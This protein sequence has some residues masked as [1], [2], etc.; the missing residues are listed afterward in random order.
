MTHKYFYFIYLF[1]YNGKL[2]EQAVDKI[3]N[4]S[5]RDFLQSQLFV[6]YCKLVR[7]LLAASLQG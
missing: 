4:V 6:Q 5:S 2:Q 3:N 1:C 7:L